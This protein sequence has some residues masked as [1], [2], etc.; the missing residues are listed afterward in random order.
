MKLQDK[1]A[2]VTGASSGIGEALVPALLARG[3]RVVV[4]ARRAEKLDALV[5]RHGADKVASV[6]VDLTDLASLPEAAR[7]ATAAFGR[8]DALI[9]NAGRSQRAAALDTSMEDVRGLMDLNFMAPVSL[10]RELAPAMVA[11][12][13]GH[14]SVVSSVA[15][16]LSTPHRSTYSATK[17]AVRGYFDSLR[18]E[19]HGTGVE[20][21]IICP[22]YVRTDIT[23]AALG[24]AGSAHGKTS[25][26]IEAGRPELVIGGKETAGVY[27]ARFSPGLVRRLAP[28]LKPD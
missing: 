20:V 25:D 6:P 4:S 26:A 27:L 12:G 19:L 28:R 9:N 16:Y 8:V 22:G 21:G 11:R 3:A 15:G 14:I 5:A 2:W 7:R 10:T 24:E 18:A 23:R 17:F 13:V 1:V